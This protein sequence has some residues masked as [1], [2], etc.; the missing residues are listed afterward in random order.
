MDRWMHE[1]ERQLYG[2][3]LLTRVVFYGTAIGVTCLTLILLYGLYNVFLHPL[4]QYPGP[5]LWNAY[6]VPYI[7]SFH[8]GEI[9]RKMK[10]MH[11]K[12]GPIVRI[13]PNELSYADSAAWKDIYGNRPGHKIFERNPLWFKKLNPGDPQSIM[14]P[15]EEAHA[16]FRRAFTQS[17]SEK[18]LR[19][20]SPVVQSYVDLFINQL[21]APVSGRKW[22]EKT[23][24]LAQ[25]L[26]FL[27][28]DIS[29]DL[30]FGESFD[31]LKNGKAHPWVELTQDFG[32][33]VGLLATVNQYP[34]ADKL[35]RFILPKKIMQKQI[36]HRDMS[37][38]K[39]RK[40]MALNTDRPD[41]I[42]PAKKHS[43]QKGALTEAEWDLNMAIFVFAGSETTAS[44]LVAIT[45]ELVQNRGALH[46]LTQEIR[47]AFE[48]ESQINHDSTG[49]MEYLNAVI[50]EGLRLCPPVVIGVPRIT[51]KDGETVCGKWVPGNTYVSYNQFAA[52]RQ[53]HNFH[54][55]NSFIPERFLS[56]SSKTTPDNFSSLQPFGVGRQ[57]CIGMKLAYIEMRLILAR[58]L[59]AF[60]LKLED[61]KDR[62][63]WGSQETYLFWEKR[64]LRVTLRPGER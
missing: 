61:E 23:V 37:A 50:N 64:P 8:R 27:T 55:P 18:S 40:R 49:N 51:P 41:F 3:S 6:R 53:P 46:R 32:K 7:I 16:R 42:T 47:G 28:F 43:D 24:D 30:S 44:A 36:D 15:D 62:W 19:D 4:R 57:S 2:H 60:D 20:Q 9:H 26:N 52:N 39:V 54:S 33:G 63:D 45:R 29:G 34:P 21:K 14:G 35:L 58:L 13:A 25:W 17:F 1:L 22:K 12:Y 38:A 48:N 5:T 56:T 31:C 11:D 10:E 59:F